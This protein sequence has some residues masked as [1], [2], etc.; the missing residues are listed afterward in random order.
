VQQHEQGEEQ[1][2]SW[3]V[4]TTDTNY[5]YVEYGGG[6]QKTGKKDGGK[7]ERKEERKENKRKQNKKRRKKE[8]DFLQT[9]E[10]RRSQ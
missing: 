5:T 7:N 3:F 9:E 6:K 10:G 2:N 1:E 4:E 8:V